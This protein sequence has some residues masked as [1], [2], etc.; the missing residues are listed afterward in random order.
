MTL[1]EGDTIKYEVAYRF[2]NQIVTR[3]FA[4][5]E[6][7]LAFANSFTTKKLASW[8]TLQTLERIK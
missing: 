2:G 1:H 6:K 3:E 7:A 5:R 8:I 4:S